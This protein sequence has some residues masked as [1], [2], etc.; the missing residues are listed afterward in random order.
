MLKTFDITY[1]DEIS[2][3]SLQTEHSTYIIGSADGYLGHRTN[4]K[5]DTLI[6]RSSEDAMSFLQK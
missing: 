2:C 6:I 3:F 4:S 1:C 5:R